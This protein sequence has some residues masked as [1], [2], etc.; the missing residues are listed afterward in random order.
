MAHF[1]PG[2]AIV[3]LESGMPTI[4]TTL[5]IAAPVERVFRLATSLDLEAEVAAR[6]GIRPVVDGGGLLSGGIGAGERV[7]WRGRQFGRMRTHRT[8]VDTLR[9]PLYFRDVMEIGSFRRFEHEHHFATMNDGTRMRDVL[10]F[11]IGWGPL[12]RLARGAVQRRLEAMLEA[13]NQAIRRAAEGEG[14]RRY[15]RED[16]ARGDAAGAGTV[17]AGP[18]GKKSGAA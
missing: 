18:R 15:L 1:G 10:R 5:E 17:V 12:G 14:W 11:E 9:A 6:W 3:G 2:C 7:T 4:R 13:R 16:G 8:L